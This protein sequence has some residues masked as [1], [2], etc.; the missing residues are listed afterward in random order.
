MHWFVSKRVFAEGMTDTYHRYGV[1][2]DPQWTTYYFDGIP[3][4]RVS[5]LPEY[6]APLY[7]VVDLSMKDLVKILGLSP[8][9]HGIDYAASPSDLRVDYLRVYAAN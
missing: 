9:G 7:M 5:T 8:E 4:C 6:K 1:M 3:Q 2:V